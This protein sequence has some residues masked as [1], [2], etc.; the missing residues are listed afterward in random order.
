VVGERCRSD[1]SRTVNEEIIEETDD[2]TLTKEPAFEIPEFT[3][4][5][6]PKDNMYVATTKDNMYVTK[7]SGTI[8][9]TIAAAIIIGLFMVIRRRRED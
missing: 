9:A 7:N 4:S 3:P 2:V 8:I 5:K 6:N 1:T